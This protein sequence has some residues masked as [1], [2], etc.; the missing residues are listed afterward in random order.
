MIEK[1][2]VNRG[3]PDKRQQDDYFNINKEEYKST[4][5]SHNFI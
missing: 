5:A 4:Y 1:M 2:L 3:M